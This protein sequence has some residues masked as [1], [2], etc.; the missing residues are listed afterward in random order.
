MS[1]SLGAGASGQR[2]SAG[3]TLCLYD[4]EL[5]TALRVAYVS[6]A[7]AE[8]CAPHFQVVELRN[9]GVAPIEDLT[10][11]FSPPVG[12][13][14][15]AFASDRVD[16]SRDD[17][18]TWTRVEAPRGSG[19]EEDPY[20]WSA[21]EAPA[22]ARL[23][24]VGEV[25]DSVLLRWRGV[26]QE[27]FGSAFATEPRLF[28]SASGRD[29]CQRQVRA[30]LA[31]ES[32]P[33]LRPLLTAGLVGRN[34]SRGGAFGETV[35]AAPGD[36][37]EWRLQLENAGDA[38]ARH[39]RVS[40]TDGADAL[41]ALEIG[42][43][44][45]RAA[46]GVLETPN[47]VEQ[48]RRTVL[49][50]ERAPEACALRDTFAEVSWGCSA[51]PQG[52]LSPLSNTIG[53]VAKAI[54]ATSPQPERIRIEQS[55]SSALGA[56]RPGE[57]A[58]VRIKVV[59]ATA[60]VYE[61]TIVATLPDGY[62]FDPDQP[63]QIFARARGVVGVRLETS[64]AGAPV[65]TLQ[66]ARDGQAVLQP[67]E[68][69]ELVFGARR[70]RESVLVADELSSAVRYEDA[71]GVPGETGPRVQSVRPRQARIALSIAPA[72]EPVVGAPGDAVRFEARYQNE[73][74]EVAR[75]P[76][77]AL[78]LGA[79]WAPEVPEGCAAAGEGDGRR[80]D[81]PIA[82]DLLPGEG[83]AF[84]F[85]L[86]ADEKEGPL[87]VGAELDA[88]A[89]DDPGRARGA[90]ASASTDSGA[91]GVRV[92]QRLVDAR[93]ETRDP[94]QPLD[95]GEIVT[96]EVA[97]H[98]YGAG[99]ERLTSVAIAQTLPDAL[100]YRAAEQVDGSVDLEAVLSPSSDRFRRVLWNIADFIG[101][102]VFIGHVTAE[103]VSADPDLNPRAPD[104][105]PTVAQSSSAPLPSGAPT[106][107]SAEADAVFEALGRSFGVDALI[108]GPTQAAP[109]ELSFRSPDIR[110]SIDIVDPAP[111]DRDAQRISETDEAATA[112]YGGARTTA[113]LRLEN[114]GAAPAYLD[115]I[116]LSTDGLTRLIELQEDGLDNDGDG[117]I[118]DA[119]ENASTT[120]E[121]FDGSSTIRW[122]ALRN[123]G[124]A[125]IAGAAQRIEP[126]EA[127]ERLVAFDVDPKAPPL[128]R[129]ALRARARYGAA[130]FA[131]DERTRRHLFEHTVPLMLPPVRGV[132][133]LSAT[134]IDRDLSSRVR[135][136]E[137]VELRIIAQAPP[138][139]LARA[140]MR[141]ALP[142][143][144]T[145]VEV[146]S[147]R[148]GPGL[149]CD[150][151]DAS[152]LQVVEEPG[153]SEDQA[154]QPPGALRAVAGR[155]L[156]WPLGECRAAFGADDVARSAILD[157]AATVVDAAPEASA[158]DRAAWRDVDVSAVLL[159]GAG[160]E[161][162]EIGRSALTISGPVLLVEPSSAAEPLDAA[163]VFGA[164]I[165]VRNVG[166]EAASGLWLALG[167]PERAGLDCAALT[168]SEAD[169]PASEPP[170]G[171]L[172]ARTAR[173]RCGPALY[174]PQM[175]L[176]PW[177][178]VTVGVKGALTPD[179]PLAAALNAP[180][181]V[182][183]RA[184]DGGAAMRSSAASLNLPTAQAEP[185]SVRVDALGTPLDQ[186]EVG[187][188]R[189]LR[190]RYVLPE[191]AAN[192]TL[193]VR[194]RLRGAQDEKEAGTA[195]SER[196]IVDLLRAELRRSRADVTAAA[197]PLGFKD[198]APGAPFDVARF[199]TV[200]AGEDGWTRLELDFGAL[201]PAA[202]APVRGSM[203]FDLDLL[204]AVADAAAVSA[205]RFVSAE[206]YIRADAA[207]ILG[208]SAE[209][210]QVIEPRLDLALKQRAA[211]GAGAGAGALSRRITALA[212]NRGDAPA[213]GVALSGALPPGVGPDP[214]APAFYRFAETV[215]DEAGGRLEPSAVARS[216]ALR[217]RAAPP[218]VYGGV[219][220]EGARFRAQ[221]ARRAPPVLPGECLELIAPISISD[222]RRGS[223]GAAPAQSDAVEV[224]IAEYR[225]RRA[226]AEPGRVYQ[227]AASATIAI[228]RDDLSIDAPSDLSAAVGDTVRFAFRVAPPRTARGVKLSVSVTGGDR[229]W[230]VR[231]DEDEDGRIGARDPIWRDGA[232]IS[233]NG[234]A[235]IAEGAVIGEASGPTRTPVRLSAVG[236]DASGRSYSALRE[237]SLRDFDD[238]RGSVPAERSMAVD[239]DCDG[240]LSDETTQDSLFEKVKAA[241]VGECVVMRLAFENDGD[242][243][244]EN[245]V[246]ED[247]IPSGV[248][249][250]AGEERFVDTPRGLV[251]AFVE[252]PDPKTG[253]I[254][255]G[256]VGA[257]SPGRRG[258]VLYLV[259]LS[260]RP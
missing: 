23:G 255:F 153:A 71:C 248:T 189:G 48:G 142:P 51:G 7:P 2:P 191:G 201:A 121:Q 202:P 104:G 59:N 214:S 243:A 168:F 225:S 240:S 53:G 220:F 149:A 31:S 25:D 250:V 47:L 92:S 147:A 86:R 177:E 99:A 139:G 188:V 66:G 11:S 216:G 109:L 140:E 210:G 166:D 35:N 184:S 154:P 103:V 227:G 29:A 14:E 27:G 81:C 37:V 130:P 219:V 128:G 253:R 138:S 40:V 10:L 199:I 52:G 34:L 160:A 170:A 9:D 232:P 182:G 226:A 131:Q 112:I 213:F 151:V 30:P 167:R 159:A 64:D 93:G 222:A 113:R 42:D 195:R 172:S 207:E 110:L 137:R 224:R 211:P 164:E 24:P 32:A 245:L 215:S 249:F 18:A 150:G 134:S 56:R 186:A 74:D 4:D 221:P 171:A 192:V 102:G 67:G 119:S 156:V 161:A 16:V 17:G 242:D 82:A 78:V 136:G 62:A 61:P 193:G 200:T 217:A 21:A 183:A 145:E 218:R 90:I 127:I 179:A 89:A 223:A 230:T 187:A 228:P 88:F 117:S 252:G 144:L 244:I 95:V 70:V 33:L 185:P 91:I 169:W 94:A 13:D 143:A 111:S 173:E 251:G 83:G 55:M 19:A 20:L 97:A 120:F 178:A 176:E 256:Y 15:W 100:A 41:S 43:P 241:G 239:R 247:A 54:L 126:G 205:G 197:A 124:A 238:E 146:L 254:R 105:G 12:A 72:T 174:D 208:V 80:F 63:A 194:F 141:V 260:E 246:I 175:R 98:W 46:S 79:G 259:R 235:Y 258:A 22:L 49:F 196:P 116:Q 6:S 36:E 68:E 44:E 190:A 157:F 229:R 77:I 209:L 84:A 203:E 28:F 162:A 181:F 101:D 60:P 85:E 236:V 180:I 132:A 8:L 73:G 57:T 122:F 198:T 165:T 76:R 204:T 26:Y 96:L 163:D 5:E 114:R 45:L 106:L 107:A 206:A 50:R 237:I 125:P 257:L 135:H 212:C 158:E 87:F 123:P 38:L 133:V 129:A 231:R 148:L 108:E 118:D 69:A 115:W 233:P 3:E 75:A 1:P 39:V 65:F 152:R 58:T 155:S 234:A